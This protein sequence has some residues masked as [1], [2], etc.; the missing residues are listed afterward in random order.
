MVL[1]ESGSGSEGI[2]V[3]G[4]WTVEVTNPDGSLARKIQFSN[5]ITQWGFGV[6]AM[7]MTHDQ[8]IADRRIWFG[9]SN[10]EIQWDTSN[11]S[12]GEDGLF[13]S[14]P[15]AVAV[16]SANSDSAVPNGSIWGA[17]CTVSI[18]NDSKTAWI[19]QITGTV[20]LGSG[21]TGW[22]NS[23][24]Y[25]EFSVKKFYSGSANAPIKVVDGQYI[26]AEVVYSFN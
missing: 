5:D 19:K 9:I 12:C 20:K 8:S 10:T 17:G 11:I 22:A 13:S 18:E 21:D 3:H 14:S 15:K 25:I 4:D 7:L 2:K 1:S 6:L 23:L 26:S 24:G 16:E